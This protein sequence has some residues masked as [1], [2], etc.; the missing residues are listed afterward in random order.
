MSQMGRIQYI[1]RAL[2]QQGGVTLAEVAAAFEVSTRQ[3]A[4]DIEYIRYQ[5]DAPLEYSRSEHKYVLS[6]PWASYA[7]LDQ[8]M[9]IMGS[10]MKSLLEKLPL[11]SAM[12]AELEELLLDGMSSKARRVMGKVIYRAP[13]IDMPD[14]KVFSAVTEALSDGLCLEIAYRNRSGSVHTRITEPERLINYESSWYM[15]AYDHR[16]GELRTFHLSRIENFI[17][18]QRKAAERDESAIDKY[19]SG[20]FGI[21]LGQSSELYTIRFSSSVARTVSSQ[22]WH[23]KQRLEPC[24][25]GSVLLTLPAVSADELINRVL[26]FGE[27]AVP[28]APEAFVKAYRDKV[29]RI[30]MSITA[31]QP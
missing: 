21:F 23:E 29:G 18:L 3:A 4:R 28:V 30:W 5:L 2:V 9:I 6:G 16:R 7:N 14:Y 19:M 8:R 22:V 25:D 1:I 20:S 31:S 17:L 12:E 24:E 11:G 15:V 10:Y 27:N 26:A 13:A